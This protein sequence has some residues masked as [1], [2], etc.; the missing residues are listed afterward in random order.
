M[1][2]GAALDYETATSH[3]VTVRVTDNGGLTRDQAVTIGV[4]NVNEAPTG[5]VVTGSTVAENS[6][7]GTVVATPRRQR[8]RYRQHLHLQPGRRAHRPLPGRRQPAPGEARGHP[9]L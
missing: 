9:R 8:P 6:A 7:A 2:Q 3:A 4:T 1:K 5:L